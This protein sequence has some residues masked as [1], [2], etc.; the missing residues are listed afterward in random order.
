MRSRR[1]GRTVAAMLPAL[2]LGLLTAA[3]LLISSPAYAATSVP[4]PAEGQVAVVVGGGVKSVKVNS[5]PAGVTVAGGVSKGRFAVAVVRP[6]GVTASGKVVLTVRGRAKGV[7]TF[8]AALSA[9]RAPACSGLGGLLA[10]RLKGGADVKALSGVLSAKL[11]GKPAPAGAPDVLARLG[12]GALPASPAGPG[13][14]SKPIVTPTPTPTPKPSVRQCDND[15][16]D[17]KDGQTDW[18]DPG[19]LGRGRQHGEQRGR[20]GGRVRRELRREH[21]GGDATGLFA[22]INSGC[23]TFTSV[24]VDAAPGIATCKVFTANSNFECTVFAPIAHATA[25]DGKATDMADI[26]LELTGPAKCDRIATIAL[27]RPNGEVAE[28]QEP[29]SSCKTG[30]APPPKCSNGK[31]DDGDGMVD[32]RDFAG[33]S[34]PDPGCSGPADTSEDSERPTPETCQVQVGVFDNNP[35]LP[36]MAVEGCGVI[37]GVWFKPPGQA[38]GC[39][40]VVGG[41]DA[42]SCTL[43]GGTGGATFAP[44]NLEVLLAVPIAANPTCVPVTVALI[45][46]D[47]SVWAD[48]VNWC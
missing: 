31:D 1:V 16:D 29:I 7:K 39:A 17:D 2:R 47:D 41:N 12:L 5:A 20:G 46:E 18:E 10:K 35:R 14:I 21:G 24:E 42:L 9:G 30:S 4:I 6:R 32:A 27:F 36:G 26:L 45:R 40:Y 15:V 25:K 3:A 28:L 22:A 44:T 33:V 34:D 48:R 11:C 38:V 8:P 37:K 43:K 13:T 23:G 19:L